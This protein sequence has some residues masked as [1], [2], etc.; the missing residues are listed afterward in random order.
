MN[1]NSGAELFLEN[2]DI[3]AEFFY[4]NASNKLKQP[5]LHFEPTNEFE[6]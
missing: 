2:N 6:L 1:W 5:V 3:F 4:A